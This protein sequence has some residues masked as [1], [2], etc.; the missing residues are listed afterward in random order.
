M[1]LREGAEEAVRRAVR[2]H[3]HTQDAQGRWLGAER[4]MHAVYNYAVGLALDHEPADSPVIQD[5][6]DFVESCA[7]PG[8]GL[9]D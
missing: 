6:C 2:W 8:G 3:R 5:L 7:T 9:G 4:S 1:S